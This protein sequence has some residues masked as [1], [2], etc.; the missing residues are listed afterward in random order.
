MDPKF[1]EL[2]PQERRKMKMQLRGKERLE[3]IYGHT[4]ISFKI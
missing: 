4:G 1:D 3:L 2:S